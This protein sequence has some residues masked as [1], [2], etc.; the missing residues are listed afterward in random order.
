MTEI[1]TYADEL[2]PLTRA[3][4]LEG[5]CLLDL[6][7]GKGGLCRR[8]ASE[9]GAASVTGIDAHPDQIARAKEKCDTRVSFH[10]GRAE[11]LPLETASMDVAIL[12]KS[13]H[14][15]PIPSMGAALSELARVLVPGGRAYIC[16]PAYEGA[17]NDI[18]RIFHDEGAERAAALTAIE[19]A[20][21]TG[22]FALA[23]RIDYLR[24]L[25]FRDLEDFR[26]RMMNLPWLKSGI[27]PAV[28]AGVARQWALH[29]P[30]DEPV[31]FESRML[32]FVLQTPKA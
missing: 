22:V 26:A 23:D 1:Q 30:P 11:A 16:E 28:E 8:I 12:M 13:L 19:Q 3:L 27:T 9:T 17:F 15:V 25:A 21:D 6:G 29:G 4:D 31:D 32:V 10:V 7:C 20:I 24:P 18:M 5:R 2:V 14:H